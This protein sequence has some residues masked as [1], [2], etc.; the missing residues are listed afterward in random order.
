MMQGKMGQ[1]AMDGFMRF[2]LVPGLG[3]G[4]GCSTQDLMRWGCWMPGWRVVRGR[5]GWW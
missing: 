4:A 1:P 5:K 3:M 2:Y